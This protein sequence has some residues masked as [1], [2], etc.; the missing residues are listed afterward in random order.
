MSEPDRVDRVILRLP[1]VRGAVFLLFLSAAWAVG[2]DYAKGY[3]M[4]AAVALAAMLLS[5]LALAWTFKGRVPRDSGAIPKE[6]ARAGD[7]AVTPHPGWPRHLF[8]IEQD[9]A[10]HTIRAVLALRASRSDAPQAIWR[11]EIQQLGD[12]VEERCGALSLPVPN[13]LR[14]KVMWADRQSLMAKDYAGA[15]A[16]H[17][18]KVIEA[19]GIPSE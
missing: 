16:G 10:L 9:K 11:R 2:Y 14:E 1:V 19:S 15:M 6:P 17:L 7:A 8:T 12:Y 5:F 13:D 3:R 18:A 4:R